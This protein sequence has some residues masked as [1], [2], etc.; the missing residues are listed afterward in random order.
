MSQ[1]QS[2]AKINAFILAARPKTLAA[3]FVPILVSTAVAFSAL[4]SSETKIK[5][6]LT[7][8][9]ILSSI[10]IQI[11]TNFINDAIDFKKGADSEKRIGPKR[12][13]QSGLL[14]PKQVLFGGGFSFFIA[15]LFGIPL[16]L[17][18]GIPILF[19]GI[20]SIICGYIYTGGPYPLAYKGLGEFFVIL[21]FGI[22]AVLGVY[23]IQT[24]TVHFH[25]FIAG[26]QIGFLATVLISINNFRDYLEDKKVNKM[27]LA[28]R[29]G[30]NFARVEIV[31]LFLSA[32]LLNIYWYIHGFL[33]TAFLPL[34]SLPLVIFVVRGLLKN[35]PSPLFNKYLGMSAAIQMLFGICMSIGFFIR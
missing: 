15:T 6:N 23:Y 18:G 31:L 17:A 25:P 9:A 12:M 13:T 28:A 20:V 32:F 19:I 3:A 2:Q 24:G 4:Q 21:F 26:L 35:E 27:T 34:L 8:F 29:F 11:G 22:V 10:F 5:W 1:E 30:K 33:W 7:L 16:I 14:T